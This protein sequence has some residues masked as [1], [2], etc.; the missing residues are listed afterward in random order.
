MTGTGPGGAVE[1]RIALRLATAGGVVRRVA[2]RS[3]RPV[4]ASEGLRGR[5]A[6]EAVRLL[7]RLFAICGTAQAAA[8]LAACEQALG[9]RPSAAETAARA[10]LLAAETAREHAWRILIDWPPLI[11]ETGD[12][13]DLAAVRRGLLGL[14]A[15]LFPV[16]DWTRSG[17]GT[18]RPDRA[19][20]RR[21]IGEASRRIGT[22]ILAGD[23]GDP[24][25]EATRDGLLRWAAAGATPAARVVARIV[26]EGLAGFGASAIAPMPPLDPAELAHRLA[27]DAD[28]TWRARPDWHGAVYETG[29]LARL[30]DHPAIA[31]ILRQD[32]NGL[33]ARLAARLLELRS[34]MAALPALVDRL[35][36]AE[37]GP[38]DRRGGPRGGPGPAGSG[39]GLGVVEAARGRLVHRVELED[40]R[41]RRYQVLAPTEWNF[42]PDGPL[43]RGLEGAPAADAER[44]AALMVTALDPCVAWDLAVG[45]ADA[46]GGGGD[47]HA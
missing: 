32:G 3:G 43:A 13:A 14:E 1:G 15:A 9:L 25:A 21:L 45:P 31:E 12:A 35:D 23:P 11:G 39:A 4:R 34:I 47:G 2:I 17:G 33:L 10:V 44:R 27:A 5:S 28:G 29:P 41:V 22:A 46:E 36:V 19:A 30:R 16:G 18:L 24:A 8:G 42:H 26:A 20:A 6:A 7:P 38:E 37:A 40:G